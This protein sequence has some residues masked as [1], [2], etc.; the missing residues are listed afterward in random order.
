M[1]TEQPM[2]EE[3]AHNSSVQGSASINGA[4]QLNAAAWLEA[5][6]ALETEFGP[7]LHPEEFRDDE[8]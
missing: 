2:L 8:G 1:A 7:I 3:R 4:P 5:L 6:A